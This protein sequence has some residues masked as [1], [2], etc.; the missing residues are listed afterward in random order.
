MEPQLTQQVYNAIKNNPEAFEIENIDQKPIIDYVLNA[1]K[2]KNFH[3]VDDENIPLNAIMRH[4]HQIHKTL[5]ID[6]PGPDNTAIQLKI[7]MLTSAKDIN[8]IM[9]SPTQEI[10]NIIAEQNKEQ[11]F[12]V[13]SNFYFIVPDETS[14][15]IY[16]LDATNYV[17]KDAVL[18][19]LIEGFKNTKN[20]W[21]NSPI[22][23]PLVIT[24]DILQKIVLHICQEE[25]KKTKEYLN[26]LE[27]GTTH[28]NTEEEE[29][30]FNT[31]QKQKDKEILLQKESK[32]FAGLSEKHKN[33]IL[34]Q[35]AFIKFMSKQEKNQK[36]DEE[37]A[38]NKEKP[39]KPLDE[40]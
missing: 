27:Q 11:R 38:N 2:N 23:H 37:N 8:T 26:M 15:L 7:G 33:A 29:D 13:F 36:K 28:M 30:F 10:N 25:L 24:K 32:W 12:R 20:V 19:R 21:G 31:L 14:K 16:K 18:Y 35:R 1:L 6:H 4:S 3:I 39:K 17:K 34:V 40:T 22:Q 5:V 9:L